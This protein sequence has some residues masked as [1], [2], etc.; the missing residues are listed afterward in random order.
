MGFILR[1]SMACALFLGTTALVFAQDA[2]SRL[3]ATEARAEAAALAKDVEDL[4]DRLPDTL[5]EVVEEAKRKEMDG[6]ILLTKNRF[7]ESAKSFM[8]AASLYR[9]AVDDYDLHVEWQKVEARIE[10][11]RM[12]SV[13]ASADR[14]QA[15][16]DSHATAREKFRLG[17]GDAALRQLEDTL[18]RYN[19]LA[20]DHSEPSLEQAVSGQKKVEAS[21]LLVVGFETYDLEGDSRSLKRG[22]LLDVLR[23]A[24]TTEKAAIAALAE[25]Q[26]RQAGAL[27]IAADNLYVKAADLQKQQRLVRASLEAAHEAQQKAK[28]SLEPGQSSHAIERGARALD[29]AASLIGDTAV[30]A[31]LEAAE[32]MIDG[33]MQDF[34]GAISVAELKMLNEAQKIYRTTLASVNRKLLKKHA[35]YEYEGAE[36]LAASAQELAAANRNVDARERLLRASQALKEAETLAGENRK[37]YEANTALATARL[38]RAIAVR[39]RE[40]AEVALAKLETLLGTHDERVGLFRV[41]VAS[42]VDPTKPPE[43]IFDVSSVDGAREAW[44]HVASKVDPQALSGRTKLSYDSAR[45]VAEN[46]RSKA[47]VG[48]DEVAIR[49]FNEARESLTTAIQQ[50]RLRGAAPIIADLEHAIAAQDVVAAQSSL[51]KLEGLIPDDPKLV[52]Y[53]VKVALLASSVASS[54]STP[55]APDGSNASP[56][57]PQSFSPPTVPHVHTAPMVAQ[58]PVAPRAVAPAP[59]AGGVSE[60]ALA[61]AE[62][63]LEKVDAA[64]AANDIE[65]ANRVLAEAEAQI[66][67]GSVPHTHAHGT[68]AHGHP[69]EHAVTNSTSPTGHVKAIYYPAVI[70]QVDIPLEDDAAPIAPEP[71]LAEGDPIPA[72]PV[73]LPEIEVPEEVIVPDVPLATGDEPVFEQ[74]DLVIKQASLLDAITARTDVMFLQQQVANIDPEARATLQKH[75][76]KAEAHLNEGNTHLTSERYAQA[77]NSYNA[78]GKLYRHVI[79]SGDILQRLQ[80][81][82]EELDRCEMIASIFTDVSAYPKIN[83]HR[84]NADGYVAAGEIE[85]AINELKGATEICEGLL[86]DDDGKCGLKDAIAARTGMLNIRRQ[87]PNLPE[88]EMPNADQSVDDTLWRLALARKSET[89]KMSRVNRQNYLVGAG[90]RTET[91]GHKALWEHKYCLA[92]AL[93]RTAETYYRDAI[94]LAGTADTLHPLAPGA[95]PPDVFPNGVR[96]FRYGRVYRNPV[97]LDQ[98]GKR[99]PTPEEMAAATEYMKPAKFLRRIG[100]TEE[101]D[102]RRTDFLRTP[103]SVRKP[104]AERFSSTV[105]LPPPTPPQGT[106][107]IVETEI[108]DILPSELEDLR[109]PTEVAIAVDLEETRQLETRLARAAEELASS[110]VYYDA[111]ELSGLDR[112]AEL[113][114]MR[115]RAIEAMT[116]AESSFAELQHY[117]QSFDNGLRS[118]ERA[119][120]AMNAEFYHTAKRLLIQS[121]EEFDFAR[122]EAERMAVIESDRRLRTISAQ[123]E[124]IDR[125]V[126]S[127]LE[128]YLTRQQRTIIAPAIVRLEQAIGVQD[129]LRAEGVIKEL[130]EVLPNG[131]VLAELRAIAAELPRPKKYLALDLGDGIEMQFV[132]IHPG[133]FVMS[134]DTP[135]GEVVRRKVSVREPYYVGRYEVTQEQFEAVMGYNPS[136]HADPSHPV[137]NVTWDEAQVFMSKLKEMFWYLNVSLPTEAQWEF[138]CRAGTSAEY[139]F[140]NNLGLMDEYGWYKGNANGMHHPVG[141]KRPNPWG[142]YDMH[143]NVREWCLDWTEFGLTNNLDTATGKKPLYVATRG[144]SWRN[145]A[146]CTRSSHR[147]KLPPQQRHRHLG[148]RV[149]VAKETNVALR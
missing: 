30:D 27:F 7:G 68:A 118:L 109:D 41:S 116:L 102:D 83:R 26:Y 45:S 146:D 37:N 53:R 149:V 85:N 19:A 124:P 64:L 79:E 95:E 142:I 76:I 29:D 57:S 82:R 40:D 18:E 39:D 120:A 4:G 113:A 77:V 138:A 125:K 20:P 74:E 147:Y 6:N 72:P 67:S 133:S 115:Q 92:E 148:F 61:Q 65:T 23:R 108:N 17:H 8:D 38:E 106:T 9:K 60:A 129:G 128:H 96:A 16:Q 104:P 140:G 63:T 24:Q 46:A 28:L 127:V 93:F 126:Q 62:A 71:A 89:S 114:Q 119:Q 101:L 103:E 55:G 105:I 131:P 75:I 84:V 100:G 11:A 69:H 51:S 2:G 25:R 107:E 31:E 54:Q 122:E 88:P 73:G 13:G 136:V 3:E 134:V 33:A 139:S 10:R 145:T 36:S 78:A 48:Q 22:S 15:A 50:S 81:A 117:P 97:E 87:I 52:D 141:S 42:I 56:L 59:T 99:K 5:Q 14:L 130:E 66:S 80:A 34:A 137:E 70:A 35:P 91:T 12:L 143:G 32:K 135:S 58:A 144:G 21:K 123:V 49:M 121:Q 111:S 86:P 47:L 112:K 94:L 43:K 132:L 90:L 98:T 1:S 44:L 110:R